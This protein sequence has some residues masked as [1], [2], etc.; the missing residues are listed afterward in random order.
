MPTYNDGYIGHDSLEHKYYVRLRNSDFN[1][2]ESNIYARLMLE[3]TR[4]KHI[5]DIIKKE[6]VKGL[7]TYA[8]AH[9]PSL[10]GW[11]EDAWSGIQDAWERI[12]DFF[13]F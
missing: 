4:G 1:E 8:R 5:I 10:C 2:E 9:W 7:L 11:I 12:T 3:E 13:G 6:G